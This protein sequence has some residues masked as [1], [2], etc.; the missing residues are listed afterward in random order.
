MFPIAKLN[1]LS[2]HTA[3]K[4]AALILK[5]LEMD[6]S[7]ERARW[8]DPALHAYLK[9]LCDALLERSPPRGVDEAAAAAR[10]ERTFQSAAALLRGVNA[11]RHSLLSLLGVE[12]AEWDLIDGRTGVL[13]T[14]ARRIFPVNVYLE[15]IRSP[16]NVGAILR[17]AEALGVQRLYLS[18]A[19]PLP[20]HARAQRTARGAHLS[21]PWSVGGLELAAAA[22]PVLALETGGRPLREFSFPASGTVLLGSEELGLSPAALALADHSLGRVSIPMAGA[23]RSLNVAVA[24]G[25]L[26]Q[27]WFSRLA[28][29][30]SR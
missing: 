30:A 20:T 29:D 17:T 14:A 25:I 19:T 6:L 26:M 5:G 11:L 13:D 22:G 16:F 9:A 4:K 1:E 24:F 8:D 3:F 15:D 27:W 10:A 23:K 18:P 12:A 28:A 7:H 21:V 2:P